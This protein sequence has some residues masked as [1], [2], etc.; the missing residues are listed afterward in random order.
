M[1]IFCS[2]QK[3]AC[4][5]GGTANTEDLKFS[6]FIFEVGVQVIN[7]ALII[8]HGFKVGDIYQHYEK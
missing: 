2:V 6:G 5:R 3:Y 7:H 4:G 1:L 8:F